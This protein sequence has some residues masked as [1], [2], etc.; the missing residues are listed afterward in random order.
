MV[1]HVSRAQAKDKEKSLRTFVV[2]QLDQPS[3]LTSIRVDEAEHARQGVAQRKQEHEKTKA[4]F[5]YVGHRR[6]L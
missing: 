5:R 3:R 1:L 6:V 4:V 2:L